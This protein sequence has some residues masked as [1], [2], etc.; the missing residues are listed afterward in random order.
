MGPIRGT[1]RVFC[2][3]DLSWELP[4][5]RVRSGS[6]PPSLA[7][8]PGLPLDPAPVAPARLGP[9]SPGYITLAPVP[10]ARS[11]RLA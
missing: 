2:E 6:E 8:E 7:W 5:I 3:L 10:M 9:P 1:S 11:G 4:P